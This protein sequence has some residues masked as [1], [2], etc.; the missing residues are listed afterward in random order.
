MRRRSLAMASLFSALSRQNQTTLSARPGEEHGHEWKKTKRQ[1]RRQAA[2]D[3]APE[4]QESPLAA[5]VRQP[6]KSR[7]DGAL[8]RALHELR[9]HPEGAALRQADHRHRADRL[10]SLAL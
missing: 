3:A 4:G 1:E 7:H 10:R 2:R 8:S 5:L 6:G 9:P